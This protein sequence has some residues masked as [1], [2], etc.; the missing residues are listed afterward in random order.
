MALGSG[1]RYLMDSVAA[2][3]GAATRG[4]PLTRYY[5]ESGT[6]PGVF[7]GAGLNRLALEPGATVSEQ[8]LWRMLGV[9]ADP[10]T[11]Q[12]LGSVPRAGTKSQAVAGFDLTFSPP[13]S[14]STMWALA[15]EP[16]REVLYRC[17]RRAI[18]VVIGYLETEVLHSRSGRNGIVQEDIEGAVAVSFTHWD[19][20][21]GDP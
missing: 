12:P 7:V 8:H 19:N 5:S 1:F 11:G 21:S 15:D 16:T 2:G 18:D 14:F 10:V 17:H 13:K 20:R 4:T 9:M 3:D 6:P